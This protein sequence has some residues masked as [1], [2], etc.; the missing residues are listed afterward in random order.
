MCKGLNF[1]GVERKRLKHTKK[2]GVNGGGWQ[3]QHRPIWSVSRIHCQPLSLPKPPTL[4]LSLKTLL[5]THSGG[6]EGGVLH[7]DSVQDVAVTDI[8]GFVVGVVVRYQLGCVDGVK[9][10]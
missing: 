3:Q 9:E 6:G 2:V 10:F 1:R 5:P 4:G 8:G 7:R